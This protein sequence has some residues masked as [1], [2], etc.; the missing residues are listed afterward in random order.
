MA[1]KPSQ[2]QELRTEF[3]SFKKEALDIFEE[4]VDYLW[5]KD[6]LGTERVR[7]E[8]IKKQIKSLKGE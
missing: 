5:Q 7:S 4:I 2:I 6:T 1:K 3:Q 8:E